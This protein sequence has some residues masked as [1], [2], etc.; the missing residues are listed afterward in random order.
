MLTQ[1]NSAYKV[2]KHI[3]RDSTHVMQSTEAEFL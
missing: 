1:Q 2:L 3:Q